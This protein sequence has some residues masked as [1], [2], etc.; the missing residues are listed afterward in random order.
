MVSRRFS[1]GFIEFLRGKY[2]VYDVKSIINL[3]EQMYEE[4]INLIRKSKYDD[5][6]YCFLN[7]NEE[8]KEVVLNRIY[9][10]RYANEYCEAK[11]KFNLLRDLGDDVQLDLDFYTKHIK[12]RWKNPEWGFPKGRRDAPQNRG[13]WRIRRLP[14]RL[15]DWI[16]LRRP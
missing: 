12:P 13:A 11:I 2:D 9:E 15:R 7:R 5:L 10:G 3:F 8:P 4:E 14:D 6:L 16:R 1:L